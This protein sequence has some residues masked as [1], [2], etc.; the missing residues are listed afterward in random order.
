MDRAIACLISCAVTILFLFLN[1]IVNYMK[2]QTWYNVLHMQYLS[3]IN[4]NS[5]VEADDIDTIKEGKKID[6]KTC[7]KYIIKY[8][9]AA[10]KSLQTIASV[11]IFG[12]IYFIISGLITSIVG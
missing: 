3:A 10:M 9:K 2:A 6:S 11:S 4:T 5:F 7:I 1:A 12:I 8:E